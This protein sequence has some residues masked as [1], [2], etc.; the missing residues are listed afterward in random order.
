MFMDIETMTF[1]KGCL[2]MSSLESMIKLIDA[3][4]FINF[5]DS[6]DMF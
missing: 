6:H 5:L 2:P 4:I 1:A 3:N